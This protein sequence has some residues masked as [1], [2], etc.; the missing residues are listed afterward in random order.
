MKS[1]MISLLV[2]GIA[3]GGLGLG[4]FAWF[5]DSD[6]VAD[7]QIAAGTLDLGVWTTV[8]GVNGAKLSISNLEPSNEF[9]DLGYIVIYNKGSIDL[10]WLAYLDKTGGEL[11]MDKVEF[12]LTRFPSEYDTIVE[13][14]TSGWVPS[15]YETWGANSVDFSRDYVWSEVSSAASTLLYS[16]YD[17]EYNMPPKTY[18]VF[19]VAAKLNKD[20]G[21]LQQGKF[22]DMD[23]IFDSTQFINDEWVK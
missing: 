22:A 8:N 4:T 11:N 7:N 3:L 21:D 16:T 13:G 18:Q 23:V 14:T 1:Y 10:K 6:T 17:G 20:T 19:R 5:T 2:I 9:Q 12:Q 15:G